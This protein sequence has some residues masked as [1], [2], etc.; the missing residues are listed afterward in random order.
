MIIIGIDPGLTKANP[1]GLA[2]VDMDEDRIIAA[3]AIPPIF[4]GFE[5][6]LGYL[7]DTLH[8]VIEWNRH[9]IERVGIAYEYPHY[10]QNAQ[11]AIKLAH[12]GGVV[13]AVA[14]INKLPVV[15]VQP[16]EAKIALTGDKN[17]SKAAMMKQT[18][19]VYERAVTKDEADAVGIALAGGAKLKEMRL[20][21]IGV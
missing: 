11:V 17:A 5:Q 12:V 19:L 6:R 14:A 15:A 4:D 21:E 18:R 7:A 8:T 20:M 1:T 10:Q 3:R 2:T 13:C 9:H 16:V